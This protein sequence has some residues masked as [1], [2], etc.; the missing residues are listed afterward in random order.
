MVNQ[1]NPIT[2]NFSLIN[3]WKFTEVSERKNMINIKKVIQ[4]QSCR[5][6]NPP[7]PPPLPHGPA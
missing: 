2:L 7:P 4:V 6:K 3:F 5:G 1:H